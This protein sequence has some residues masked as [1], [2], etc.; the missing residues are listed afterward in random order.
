MHFAGNH[1]AKGLQGIKYTRAPVEYLVSQTKNMENN[2]ILPS[3]KFEV[4]KEGVNYVYTKEK[5][6]KSKI[7]NIKSSSIS[8]C[9]QDVK[10]T[11]VFSIIVVNENVQQQNFTIFD[12]HNFLCE[13]TAQAKKIACAISAALQYCG[14]Q[15]KGIQKKVVVELQTN[16]EL[17]KKEETDDVDV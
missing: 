3:I 16:G 8:Y 11:R 5:K 15:M 1:P 13:S 12:C 2:E 6:D 14:E 10:Y 9:A 7:V 4:T 17:S